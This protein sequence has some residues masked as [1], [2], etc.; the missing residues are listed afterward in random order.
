MAIEVDRDGAAEVLVPVDAEVVALHDELVGTEGAIIPILTIDVG[1][2]MVLGE[3]EDFVVHTLIRLHAGGEGAE[4][5]TAGDQLP[6][7]AH[8]V[9]TVDNRVVRLDVLT[10]HAGAGVGGMV[11]AKAMK[12]MV[13]SLLVGL[14][15]SV[16]AYVYIITDILKKLTK[17]L[18]NN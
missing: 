2:L 14:V 4:L 17:I 10:S 15:V 12:A 16:V 1:D 6:I 11:R 18:A 13:N 3:L 5:D 8:F 9:Y 7:R